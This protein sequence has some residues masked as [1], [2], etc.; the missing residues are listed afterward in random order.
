MLLKY[1]VVVQNGGDEYLDFLPE[2]S[3]V[4]LLHT[5]EM[6]AD[7]EAYVEHL[8]KKQVE[9]NA[10]YHHWLKGVKG[11]G[12]KM[13]ACILFEID[14]HIASSPSKIFAYAGISPGKTFG[15]QMAE[16]ATEKVEKKGK[17]VAKRVPTLTEDLVA[18]DRLTPGYLCPYN[19]F[20]KTKMMGVLSTSFMM[21]SSPYKTFYS[22]MKERLVQRGV[23]AAG[24]KL[25][26]MHIEW[27]S[28]RY[29]IKMFF[30]DLYKNWRAF[31][32]LEVRPT[33]A[34]QYL[35]IYHHEAPNQDDDINF[36]PGR[37]EIADF[38]DASNQDD[39]VRGA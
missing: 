11:V 24:E 37:D 33:Y 35:Q 6:V 32:G 8:I 29:M 13:A 4:E 2:E 10:F 23:N 18:Q 22:N 28:R 12:P 26:P 1:D 15:R 14:I 36:L 39:V 34:E 25:T 21:S 16:S 5:Y 7:Q 20:L 19:K 9:K 17:M 31:E 30:I 27:M 3:M 38:N